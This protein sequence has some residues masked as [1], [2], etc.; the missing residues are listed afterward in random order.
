MEENQANTTLISLKDAAAM[1]GIAY[2]EAYELAYTG[3]VGYKRFP[4][5][6]LML[7]RAD[8]IKQKASAASASETESLPPTFSSGTENLSSNGILQHRYQ[9]LATVGEGG[10]GTVEK[11]RHL[12][13]DKLV[14]LKKTH[15][16]D[17]AMRRSLLR[18]AKLLAGEAVRHSNLPV[19]IDAFE[20]GNN[21]YMAMDFIDGI[22]LKQWVKANGPAP[23]IKVIEW[24]KTLLNILTFLHHLTPPIIHR[25]I[26]P[27]N[28][29]LET[30]TQ[31]LYLVDF[32]LAKNDD[33]SVGGRTPH[34][35]SPEHDS[36][37]SDPRSDIYSLGATLYFLVSDTLP[38]DVRA[39]ANGEPLVSLAS[40][41]SPKISEKFWHVILKAMALSPTKRWTSADAMLDA[42]SDTKT[43]KTL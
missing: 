20:A 17:P 9:I 4:G 18:E 32:G 34:F 16:N 3:R 43:Q 25:D 36:G 30:R 23:E 38:P 8:V 10:Y 24:A 19:V 29:I 33:Y 2:R 39:R 1:L 27:S 31:K 35:A 42:L 21:V 6:K 12:Q 5:G 26:K 37:G 7:I 11:A 14:A 15:S 40:R 41:Q 22:N 13:L 28:I